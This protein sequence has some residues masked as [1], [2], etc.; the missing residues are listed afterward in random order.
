MLLCIDISNTNTKLGVFDEDTLVASFRLST[1][2]ARTGDE[3]GVLILGLFRHEGLEPRPVVPCSRDLEHC[4][5]M[6]QRGEGP[7][8]DVHA[9]V[10]LEAAEVREG[11]DRRTHRGVGRVVVE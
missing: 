8:H 2:R 3:L 10:A 1:D 7:D 6:P 11:G 4:R 5:R 9:L